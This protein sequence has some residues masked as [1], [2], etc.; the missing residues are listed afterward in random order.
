KWLADWNAA[1]NIGTRLKTLARLR[2]GHFAPVLGL[3]R[4]LTD[5]VAGLSMGQTAETLANHFG[6]T[7]R[8]MDEYAARSHARTVRAQ[9]D[10]AFQEIIPLVDERNDFLEGIVRSEEHTS[11]LQSRENLVC[12]LLLE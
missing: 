6:I 4:G 3:V 10:D 11:E 7:R 2:P 8:E 1:K 5:P 9:Q 12:R